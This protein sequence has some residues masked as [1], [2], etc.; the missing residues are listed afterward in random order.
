MNLR[1]LIA[2]LPSPIVL[3]HGAAD[4]RVCDVTE[5][6][7]TVLPGSLFIARQGETSD[8]VRFIPQALAA[9]ATSILVDE[10]AKV[11][12]LPEGVA[13]LRAADVP[14]AS[15]HLVERFYG[16]PTRQLSLVGV[17][18]TNGKTTTTFLIWQ[19]LNAV[20][21]R[22][23]LVGTVLV[24]DGRET[25][26]AEMTTPP[27]VALSLAF[28]TMV[29]AGCTAAAIEASS[30]ALHQ[31]RVEGLHFRQGVFTNLTGD[32]LDY[33][34]SMDRYADAKAHLFELLDPKGV[35]IVNRGDSWSDR[36]VRDCRAQVLGCVESDHE[37]VF[38]PCTAWRVES[39]ISGMKLRLRGPWGEIEAVVPLIGAY[40]L[41]NILQATASCH[42]LGMNAAQ[43]THTLSRVTAPPGRLE[44]VSKPQDDLAVFV[45]YAH[46]DDALSSMLAAVA[47]TM[48][49]ADPTRPSHAKLWVVF[50]CGG[51]RDAS[52]R[53]R[54][55]LAAVR[56]AD[57]VVITSDNPRSEVPAQIIQEILAG[58]PDELKVKRVVHVERDAAIRH[59]IMSAAPG[60]V[61]VIAGKGHET[62]QIVAGPDGTLIKLHF[63]DREVARAALHDRLRSKV[64]VSV[65]THTERRPAG[66]HAGEDARGSDAP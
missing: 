14:A 60:D 43:L 24:D 27:S 18:G 61:V 11:P 1:P 57:R 25:G 35:A 26:P 56:G 5:D 39:S 62:D 45:D 15:A 42:A 30:H 16:Y 66:R 46:T 19:M 31:R 54:M 23:G 49:S 63:D 64:Q 9:G 65:R 44:R 41:M 6:S 55:G 4:V 22:C 37:Q 13:L 38:A 34:K 48:K 50:G 51:N 53:P 21:V 33:H 28:R 20:E 59:A 7:R 17:T 58:I 32:H 29:D 40:N 8:G 36:M 2:D 3:Q 10:A 12:E 47:Q 52:K